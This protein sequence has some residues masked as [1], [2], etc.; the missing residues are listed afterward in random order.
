[1]EPNSKTGGM[2]ASASA[3]TALQTLKGVIYSG[4]RRLTESEI[5]LLRQSKTEVARRV[6][7]LIVESK[8][9]ASPAGS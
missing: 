7:Q 3:M 5:V 8:D 4:P 9:Q 6:R 2:I 1:M